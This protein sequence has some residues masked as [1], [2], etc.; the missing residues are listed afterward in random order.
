M[1][2]FVTHPAKMTGDTARSKDPLAGLRNVVAPPVDPVGKARDGKHCPLG[3]PREDPSPE[4]DLCRVAKF[5]PNYYDRWAGLPVV[6]DQSKRD[7]S[8]ASDGLSIRTIPTVERKEVKTCEGDCPGYEL[9]ALLDTFK[10]QVTECKCVERMTEMNEW[11]STGCKRH[12]D[13]IIAWL[14]EEHAR[15]S[16]RQKIAA[17]FS[18][19]KAGDILF[20][21]P[22]DPCPGLVDEAIKRAASKGVQTSGAEAKAAKTEPTAPQVP[23]GEKA[24]EPQA[25]AVPQT[26]AIPLL[27]LESPEVQEIDMGRVLTWAYGVTTVPARRGTLLP[28]TLESLR[29]AG[30]TRPRLFIDGADGKTLASYEEEF[31]LDCTA[32][33]PATLVHG[34]WWL[35]LQEL[36]IRRPDSDRYAIFQDDISCVMNLRR[37]LSSIDHSRKGYLNLYTWA[38]NQE[39][40][41]PPSIAGF[42]PANLKGWGALGLVFT[43]EAVLELLKS[44]WML[45]RP[46]SADRGW[47]ALDGGVWEAMTRVGYREFVHSPSLLQHTG[48]DSTICNGKQGESPTYAGDDFDAM[49]LLSSKRV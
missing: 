46:K 30:F 45:L 20:L 3:H 11:K 29:R 48:R 13:E 40:A 35:A 6:Q 4:C 37:Y 33:N 23:L 43:Q 10:L 7:H 47:K 12:R 31:G 42:Y 25:E 17:A 28:R 22:L 18:H 8:A 49:T 14:R 5:D 27:P 32:R 39:H 19:V 16:W 34:N 26:G 24:Q 15:L 44:E 1:R 36:F 21:N 38:A 9:K 41:P 2:G